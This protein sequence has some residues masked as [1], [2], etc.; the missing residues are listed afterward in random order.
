MKLGIVSA[1]RIVK[2]FLPQFA[3]M[4]WVEVTG[5]CVRPQSEEN[6][7]ALAEQYAIPKVYTDYD[8]FLRENDMD[9]VYIGSVNHVHYPQARAAI[10][11]GRNVILEKPLT[12]TLA[13][14]EE[15]FSLAEEKGVKLMEAI[16]T[17]YLPGFTFLKEHLE[18]I[19]PIRMVM[20]NFSKRS[21]Q[22]DAYLA[23]KLPP[24][25]D[26]ACLGG[27]LNDM[28]VY[29]LHLVLGLVGAPKAMEYLPNIGDSGVDNSGA[30]VLRY[31]GFSALLTAG[32]DGEAPSYCHIQGEN[33]LLEL[34]GAPNCLNRVLL[35]RNGTVTEGTSGADATRM[36]EEFAA[37]DRMVRGEADALYEAA[38]AQSLLVM[39]VLD[40]LHKTNY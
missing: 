14:T 4:D 6:G 36:W 15:L 19:K 18:E 11:A 13:E 9:A 23:G 39:G 29:N 33:G 17:F 24:V 25:F 31:E 28:N 32:K 5:I 40:E 1:S 10:L 34:D 7:R 2:E 26:P 35:H 20:A 37:F 22:Y 21:S 12:G 3:K 8:C 27:A 16:T 30:A 38:K